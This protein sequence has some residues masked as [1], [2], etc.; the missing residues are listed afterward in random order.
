MLVVALV[1]CSAPKE[2][3]EPWQSPVYE[4][5]A[6]ETEPVDTDCDGVD[7]DADG[8]DDCSDCD[9]GDPAR[10]PGAVE[11]CDG[12]DQDCDGAPHPGEVDADADG[13]LDCQA[14]DDAGY[15]QWIRDESDG[16][17]LWSSLNA[18]SGPIS[19]LYSVATDQMFL[20]VDKHDGV[21]TCV[22]TGVDVPVGDVKPDDSVMNTE[23]SWPQSKGAETE[24]AKCDLH[25]LYPTVTEANTERGNY[26]FGE[27]T[28]AA[29]WSGGGSTLG[30]SG[31]GIVF[32]PHAA[33]KGNVARSMLYFAMRYGFPLSAAE[34]SLY[35]SWSAADPVDEAELARSSVI[36]DLQGNANPFVVCPEAVALVPSTGVGG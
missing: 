35:Q 14:C 36:F 22:Y 25:H 8:V 4:T 21:V 16:A 3:S 12:A 31:S 24:P 15:W 23:H 19:C 34:V 33:H 6:P 29:S 10:F 32:E 27:V 20:E 11:R 13:A 2:T 9:D 30:E 28:G 26:P 1:A 5:A 18:I 17:A 7:G